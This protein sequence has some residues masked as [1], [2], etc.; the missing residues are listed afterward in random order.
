MKLHV[1]KRNGFDC[2][3]PGCNGRVDRWSVIKGGSS[4]SSAAT[5]AAV[6]PA[7]APQARKQVCGCVFVRLCGDKLQIVTGLGLDCDGRLACLDCA[8]GLSAGLP[9]SK[10]PSCSSLKQ[11]VISHSI[12]RKLGKG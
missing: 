9:G 7:A 6:R 11:C 8:T 12:W 1:Q 10:V 4:S 5:A 3:Q 2:P